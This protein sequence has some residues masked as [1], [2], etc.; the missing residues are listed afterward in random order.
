MAVE[1]ASS[2]ITFVL[3]VRKRRRIE[4]EEKPKS[5]GDKF[6]ESRI[7]AHTHTVKG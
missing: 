1:P 6:F 3:L 7:K 4:M 2:R 5:F